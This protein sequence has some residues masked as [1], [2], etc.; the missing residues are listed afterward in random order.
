[1]TSR[2]EFLRNTG[3]M[4]LGGLLVPDFLKGV[5]PKKGKPAAGIGIQTFTINAFM[6]SDVKAAF[7]K[8]ADIG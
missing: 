5:S 3:A 1:M 7:K 2:R 6:G 8:L 4:A